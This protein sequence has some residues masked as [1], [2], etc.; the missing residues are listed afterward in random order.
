MPFQFYVYLFWDFLFGWIE[1]PKE[2]EV[3]QKE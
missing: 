3:D 2:D 1:V